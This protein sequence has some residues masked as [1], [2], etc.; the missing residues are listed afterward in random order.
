MTKTPRK[1]EDKAQRSR[2]MAAVKSRDTAPE[3]IV[4]SL[5][6]RLGFR[7]SL[8]RTD[9]PGSPDLAFPARQKAIFVHG[10]FWHGHG[11]KRGARVPKNNRKYWV[12]KVARNRKRDRRVVR[13]LKGLG[14]NSL[15]VW[16]CQLRRPERLIAKL[17]RFLTG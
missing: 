7:F 1:T 6:H 17:R 15:I 3:L 13:E 5:V 4:R 9:L 16:E 12:A 8:R 11:C 14:W 2:I 10:C